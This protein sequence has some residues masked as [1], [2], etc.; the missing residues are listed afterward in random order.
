VW[1]EHNGQR[2]STLDLTGS[3]VLVAGPQGGVWCDAAR[4]SEAPPITTLRIG[5]EIADPAGS[6]TEA[7]GI[8]D[9]G[10]VL[11]R[12]DGFVAWRA[13]G[14]EAAAAATLQ[15]VVAQLLR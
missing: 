10:A 15:A 1:V 6:L 8:S 3:F 11:V 5:S 2:V 12:P 9:A 4:A 7:L 14:L 13:R